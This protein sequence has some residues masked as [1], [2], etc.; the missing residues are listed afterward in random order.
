VRPRSLICRVMPEKQELHLPDGASRSALLTLRARLVSLT[1]RGTLTIDDDLGLGQNMRRGAQI[2]PMHLGTDN[3]GGGALFATSRFRAFRSP[4]SP[5][6]AILPLESGSRAP[7]SGVVPKSCIALHP[8]ELEFSRIE[9]DASQLTY[10]PISE[11]WA[12]LGEGNLEGTA[13][14]G[15]L[16]RTIH[17]EH[18]YQCT[19]V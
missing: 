6:G 19:K 1:W 7:L 16:I 4:S 3:L 18:H 9:A 12:T 17:H 14:N 5:R 2:R 10:S 8:V 11:A 13:P 15:Q